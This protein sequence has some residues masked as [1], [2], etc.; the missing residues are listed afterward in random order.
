LRTE[1][2]IIDVDGIPVEQA[3][4]LQRLMVDHLIGRRV[5]FRVWRG[6]DVAELTI[7]PVELET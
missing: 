2:V 5:T 1:D 3:G 4:D 7:T 6:G